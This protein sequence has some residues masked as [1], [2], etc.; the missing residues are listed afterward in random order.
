MKNE[1]LRELVELCR[2]GS[3]A[4]TLEACQTGIVAQVTAN[5]ADTTRSTSQWLDRNDADMAGKLEAAIRRVQ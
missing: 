5:R 3:C 4:V 1:S 2:A